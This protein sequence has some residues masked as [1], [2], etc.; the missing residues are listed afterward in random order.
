MEK[1]TTEYEIKGDYYFIREIS[2]TYFTTS[3]G[4]EHKGNTHRHPQHVPGTLVEGVYVKT[5]VDSLSDV[6]KGLATHLWTEEVHAAYEASL[7][8]QTT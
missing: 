4:I 2:T 1:I 6:V 3:D 8:V 7:K 5:N